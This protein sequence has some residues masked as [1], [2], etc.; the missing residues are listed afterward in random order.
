MSK[1]R[2]AKHTSPSLSFK[3]LASLSK[4]FWNFI[5]SKHLQAVIFSSLLPGS[6]WWPLSITWILFNLF[7]LVL[8]RVEDSIKIRDTHG[9][10]CRSIQK[11]CNN[12]FKKY[13]LLHLQIS[14]ACRR[15]DIFSFLLGWNYKGGRKKNVPGRSA[16]SVPVNGCCWLK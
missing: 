1:T 5:T 2:R 16:I 11:P 4:M 6:V 15:Q 14:A 9:A 13:T 3:S 12:S 7:H 8:I 10:S